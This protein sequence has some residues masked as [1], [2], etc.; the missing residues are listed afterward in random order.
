[1]LVAAERRDVVE[2]GRIEDPVERLLRKDIARDVAHGKFEVRTAMLR[3]GELHHSGIEVD[4]YDAKR[5]VQRG[6]GV[7]SGPRAHPHVRDFANAEQMRGCERHLLP[8]R[9]IHRLE[10]AQVSVTPPTHL[11]PVEIIHVAS[12]DSISA[13]RGL[14][15]DALRI[16]S[17]CI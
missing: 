2:H 3:F 10:I 7:A 9:R 12:G 8:H 16:Y 6:K 15:L 11:P 14:D 17:Y 5:R 1:M 13:A 4:T